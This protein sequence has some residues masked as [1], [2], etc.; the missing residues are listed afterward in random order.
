MNDTNNSTSSKLDD[1]ARKWDFIEDEKKKEFY[2]M[3]NEC[4]ST[5]M[6]KR[7]NH[8]TR[9]NDNYNN[10]VVNKDDGGG[11]STTTTAT[12]TT[13]PSYDETCFYSILEEQKEQLD[14]LAN[15]HEEK[16]KEKEKTTQSPS[17]T[18]VAAAA[19]APITTNDNEGNEVNAN[20]NVVY[21]ESHPIMDAHRCAECFNTKVYTRV[22]YNP[23]THESFYFCFSCSDRFV[24][25]FGFKP[26][27]LS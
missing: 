17:A 6:S 8:F 14:R 16:K 13:I 24:T 12:T 25:K 2:A 10:G 5:R 19:A 1:Q 7:L 22:F 9:N 20:N 18:T 11:R 4:A 3:L 21:A 26:L 23:N 15:L 27:E